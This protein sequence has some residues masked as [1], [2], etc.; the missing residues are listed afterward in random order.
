M[1]S[2]VSLSA[3]CSFEIKSAL[4]FPQ[5]ASFIFAPMPAAEQS[6]CFAIVVSFFAL[7]NSSSFISY[8]KTAILEKSEEWELKSEK[9]QK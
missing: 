9:N 5:T 2:P 7:Q 8:Q 1:L 3:I 6:N 4:L